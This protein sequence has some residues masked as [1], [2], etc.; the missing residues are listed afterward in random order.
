MQRLSVSERH[1]DH[2]PAYVLDL[3]Q[4]EHGV[5][6]IGAA[7]W[8]DVARF[9][10]QCGPDPLAGICRCVDL[11]GGHDPVTVGNFEVP[12]SVLFDHKCSPIMGIWRGSHGA[13]VAS[14]GTLTRHCW[15]GA[16]P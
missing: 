10:A 9:R 14:E 2:K 13:K 12:V 16:E 3:G 15:A 1:G 7:A 4:I 8:P 6:Q 11:S 5:D